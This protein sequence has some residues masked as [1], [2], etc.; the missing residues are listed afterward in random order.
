MDPLT[1]DAFA[2]QLRAGTITSTYATESCVRQIEAQNGP[3]N[4]FITVMA[5]E[6]MRDA[7][8]AD[9]ELANGLDR[10]PLH[11]VPIS[12]KDIVDVA[13]TVTTAASRVREG[14]V[15]TGD[16]L[17]VQR[18]R[19]AGAVIVGKTNLHEF[20]L[21][22]TNEDSAFGPARNPLDPSRSPGGSSGGSA[23][24][25]RAGMCLGSLGTDTGGS[26]RIPAAA[27]GLVGLKPGYDELPT[28]GVI[29]LSR[30]LD[31]AGPIAWTV[32]DAWHL[33]HALR[34]RP[35][36]RPLTPDTIAGAGSQTRQPG[37]RNLRFG[38]PRDYFF[39]LLDDEV[40]Q[41]FAGAVERLRAQ[42]ATIDEVRIPHAPLIGSVYTHIVFGDAAA[43]HATALDAMPEKYT[44]NVRLRLELA[45]YVLAEDYVRALDGRRVLRHEVDAAL[46]GRD[47]LL[48]PTIPIVAPSIGAAMA[49]VGATEQPVRNVMLRLTQ[50]FNL[51]GHPAVSLP[52]GAGASG[53]PCGLQIAGATGQTDTLLH[54]AR[55][56]EIALA[57]S[58]RT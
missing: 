6:A 58:V 7:A 26:I 18:L 46:T 51:T 48:L 41:S 38:V 3:L 22:T 19:S 32:T 42:G 29:P 36:A 28:A 45:R 16:A 9:R 54:V 21:G 11:G 47:G 55:G 23:A 24:S 8:K 30:T 44:P 34:D 56:V 49:R 52:C 57:E 40:A 15:A 53:L 2:R 4:A 37:V 5:E 20:A 39:D 25:V 12:V 17:L 1:I 27:C 43:Y 14:I 35:A 31:H 10:G 50:L 33:F 13:A